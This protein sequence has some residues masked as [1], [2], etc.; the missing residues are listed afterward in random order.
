MKLKLST[1][2]VIIGIIFFAYYYLIYS[3]CQAVSPPPQ[4]L[5]PPPPQEVFPIEEVTLL[6]LDDITQENFAVTPRLPRPVEYESR[7]QTQNSYNPDDIYELAGN[8]RPDNVM[9][10]DEPVTRL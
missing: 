5:Q 3:P 10:V 4:Q 7:Q 6:D 2:V 1:L 9:I 8:I